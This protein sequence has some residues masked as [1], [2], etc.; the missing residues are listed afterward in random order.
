[1]NVAIP[2]FGSRISP[3]FDFCQ[4]I[5]IVS[6][7]EDRI[8]DRKVVSVSSLTPIQRI[9]ELCNRNVKVVICGG[10]SGFLYNHLKNN[11]I[12]VVYDV[13]GEAEEALSRYLAGHLEP[14]TFCQGQRRRACR[15]GTR[16]PWQLFG[17]SQ[18]RVG[19]EK[20]EE[21]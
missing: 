6:V 9:A 4:E 2:L 5:L 19:P 8:I 1:M 14:R 7:E 12:S 21:E 10:I 13:M 20:E 18:N 17:S 3:R 15:K 16:L 11:G